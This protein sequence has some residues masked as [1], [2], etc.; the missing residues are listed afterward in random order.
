MKRM[1]LLL[2]LLGFLAVHAIA[3]PTPVFAELLAGVAETDITPQQ[4]P[5]ADTRGLHH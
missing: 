2:L 1:F 5:L 3:V 4:W